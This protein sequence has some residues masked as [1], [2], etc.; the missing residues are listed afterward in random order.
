MHIN[1]DMFR[2][3]ASG[4]WC[5][6]Y[7]KGIDAVSLLMLQPLSGITLMSRHIGDIVDV[8]RC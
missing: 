6:I 2:G 4:A 7:A 8:V 5:S 3:S 1:G